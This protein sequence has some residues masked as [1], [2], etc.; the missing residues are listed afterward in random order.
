MGFS[1][2]GLV[3]IL[4]YNFEFVASNVTALEVGL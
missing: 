1:G 2:F 4:N 3:I